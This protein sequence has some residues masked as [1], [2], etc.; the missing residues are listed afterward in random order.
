MKVPD[1]SPYCV[2]IADDDEANYQL[3]EAKLKKT[4]IRVLHAN[5]GDD[6]VSLFSINK[7]DIVIMDAMMPGK[8][9]FAATKEI[10]EISNDIPVIMLTAYVN[11]D[12]I[13]EAVT[14]GCNDYLSKPIDS[15]VL[16]SVL[17][18]WLVG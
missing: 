4:G 16:Y 6:A 5:N 18:K 14:S 15:E 10:K 7:V 8:N 9:G 13:R 11:Q 2:L 17:K 1:F 3:Y 12:S